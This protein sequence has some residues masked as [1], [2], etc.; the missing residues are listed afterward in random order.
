MLISK[1]ILGLYTL[2]PYQLIAAD[3]N[4]D[5]KVTTYDIVLLR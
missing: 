3:A 4:R 5:G 2:S 1:H